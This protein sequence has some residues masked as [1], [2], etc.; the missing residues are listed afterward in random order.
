MKNDRRGARLPVYL[1]V[2]PTM[3]GDFVWRRWLAVRDRV[4]YLML[5]RELSI[6]Y[7]REMLTLNKQIDL[8]VREKQGTEDKLE[9]ALREAE[10]WQS[11]HVALETE[12]AKHPDHTAAG[13]DPKLSDGGHKEK[14]E[15]GTND[16]DVTAEYD[17]PVF[18]VFD[19]LTKQYPNGVPAAE[20]VD[21]LQLEEELITDHALRASQDGEE[22]LSLKELIDLVQGSGEKALTRQMFAKLVI[23]SADV[24]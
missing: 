20:L 1:P 15:A 16:V 17:N 4:Q 9:G 3:Q 21:E 7:G 14:Q 12:L 8:L 5:A 11:K 10:A 24:G 13:M 22:H 19:L 2:L 23:E 18:I 6:N